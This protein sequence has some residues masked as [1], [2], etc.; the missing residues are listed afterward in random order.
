MV[1]ILLASINLARNGVNTREQNK[2]HAPL[3][4]DYASTSK[5]TLARECDVAFGLYHSRDITILI[6]LL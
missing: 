3:I 2:R 6:V 4:S 1:P 5:C